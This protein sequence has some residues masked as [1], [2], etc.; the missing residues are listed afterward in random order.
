MEARIF[1]DPVY[2]AGFAALHKKFTIKPQKNPI[3][4][5][6]EFLVEGEGIDS[7]LQ[8]IYDNEFVGILDYIKALKSLRSSIF[9][10][11]GP[12]NG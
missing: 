4:D 6:V 12:R 1:S 9:A 11:K 10:L 7:A 8:E 2:P 5:R 3:S